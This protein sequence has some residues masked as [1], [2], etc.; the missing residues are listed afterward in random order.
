[1]GVGQNRNKNNEYPYKIFASIAIKRRP[2][3]L[4]LHYEHFPANAIKVVVV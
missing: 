1:M 4:I 3:E 2:Y